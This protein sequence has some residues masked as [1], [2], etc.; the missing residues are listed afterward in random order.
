MFEINANQII[1]LIGFVLLFVSF[2][3]NHTKV[4]KRHTLEY[5]G[6]NFLGA[7]ILAWYSFQIN[8]LVFLIVNA[9]WCV[10]ALYFIVLKLFNKDPTREVSDFDIEEGKWGKK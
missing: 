7:G 3:L 2:L 6:L 1:G 5:N 4:F 10:V 8:D 9:V